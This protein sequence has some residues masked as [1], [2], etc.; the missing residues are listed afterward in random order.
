M[1]ALRR[2]RATLLA[3]LCSTLFAA[4]V[5][6]HDDPVSQIDA[7]TR[8]AAASRHPAA[9]LARRGELRQQQ[10]DW[11]GALAD[12]D[13]AEALD[14]TLDGLDVCR[15][16]ARLDGGDAA[17]AALALER[18]LARHP[19]RTDALWLRGRARA[20]IGLRREAIADFD[21]AISGLH[22][23][24]P[25][26]YLE[27]ARLQERRAARAGIDEGIRRLGP[28]P[29]LLEMASRLG[30]PLTEPASPAPVGAAI[31]AAEQLLVPRGS[32]WKYDATG[33]DRG[34][35]WRA[36][37]FD[38]SLWPAGPAPL[39]FGDPFIVTSVPFG[40]PN[41]K[42]VTT[43]F[44]TSFTY[45]GS[46]ATL[47][48]RAN[49]DDGFVAYLNGQEIARRGLGSDAVPYGRLA[50]VHEAGAYETI[51][52]TAICRMLVT[53][54]NTFAV[55]VH[56]RARRAA[57]SPWT[58]SWRRFRRRR[59][60]R[61]HAAPISRSARRPRWWFAGAP[62][63]RRPS[64][65]ASGSTSGNADR[66]RRRRL[67]PTTEHEVSCS[68]GLSRTRA[69][70][71]RWADRF[72]SSPAATTSYVRSVTAP[73]PG[74]PARHAH[75]GRSATPG[76]TAPAQARGARRLRRRTPASVRT[77]SGSCS[78]TTRTTTGTDAEY[79]GRGLR[80]RIAA[81]CGRSCCGPR[82]ATT[83]S[84]TPGRGNDYYDFFTMPTAGEAGGVALGH[85][86]LLLVRLRRHPL[87][88]SRLR[89]LEPTRPAARCSPGCASD[90]AANDA[91][92]D[93]SRSGTTRLTRRARTTRTTI[94]RQRR[95][96]A[97]HARSTRCRS[98][99][100]A[101]V[102]LVLTGT[103]IPTSAR[104]CSTATTA[105][106]AR[107][108]TM[109][110]DGGDGRPDE[111]GPYVKPHRARRR[112]RARCTRWRAARSQTIG[113]RRSTIRRWSCRSNV[114]GS[115][116]LDVD[117]NRLDAR[118]LDSQRRGARQL[119]DRE[120]ERGVGAATVAARGVAARPG[121]AQPVPGHDPHP[122]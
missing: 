119:H 17:G 101:G 7:L 116:V 71:T 8:R 29:A 16:A 54:Q 82:A 97:R 85:R 72:E 84:C 25:D 81:C 70:T 58:S 99:R 108:P 45:S 68:R 26:H 50:A 55:E 89:G 65:F 12:F 120:G 35:G 76:S 51:D 32:I 28:V 18:F 24:T 47:T 15:G 88:L 23:V 59:R 118:F 100:L 67:T 30:D 42:Y 109:K 43:Y 102:D 2:P 37:G 61:S 94:V 117:G 39:G 110:V 106:R 40:S 90:L 53:G 112:T 103:A 44:R 87:H 79:P 105:C 34:T 69:T 93:R 75:L 80:S 95:P 66:L 46:A 6:A 86:G 122:V 52:V 73:A 21:A 48:L 63:S 14:P 22:R 60:P 111:D 77:D 121:D 20:A 96:H 19:D 27:R 78:A 11:R 57:T 49:Y 1:F 31:P 107:S 92:V 113:R 74:H 5:Y 41:N 64:P 98:S 104:S 36:Q 4:P 62:T 3:V 83:S 115:M 38:D 10:G 9:L 114:L 33:T 13:A 91:A 56:Q